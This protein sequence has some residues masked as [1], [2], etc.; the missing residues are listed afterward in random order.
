MAN[1]IERSGSWYVKYRDAAGKW[2]RVVTKARS[3]AEAK[4]MATELEQRS[5]RE[6][7]G[8]EEKPSDCS[9][10]LGQLCEWW[11]A[12]RCPKR[13]LY[14]EQKRLDKHVLKT[15]L[16][17]TPLKV[18]SANHVEDQLRAMEK[19]GLGPASLNGLRGTLFTVLS[20]GRKA[21]KW[22]GANP[23]AD[24]ESRRIPKKVHRTLK[25]EEVPVLLA[26][27][28]DDWLNLFVAALYT[29]MRKGELFGLKKT[30]V[31]LAL[32][33]IV[34]ARS[35][36]NDTTKGGHQDIIPIAAPLAR[37]LR[38]AIKASPSEYVF[39]MPDG[40]MRHKE[41]DPQK[42]LR[43][44]L[45]RAGLVDGY[46]HVCRRC[47]ARGKPSSHLHADAELRTCPTCKMKLWP[48]AL[49]R[50]MH[51]HDLRHTTATLL[52][53]N[54][55][56]LHRVQRILRHKD[57]KLTTDTYGHLEVEDLRTA[58]NTLPT[59]ALPPGEVVDADYEILHGVTPELTP[60]G[61]PVVQD[62]RNPKNETPGAVDFSN[63]SGGF[64]LSGRQD[65][66]LRPLGPEPSALPG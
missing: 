35:Y 13:S 3:K 66:N 6:R 18:L 10:S 37:H 28:P 48:K 55:V 1:V 45:A 8:L 64:L 58:I 7:F 4:R 42:V 40:S 59:N 31:D 49:P 56:D 52:L 57:V 16:G 44:A 61:P 22:T 43:H 19:D 9:L 11:L 15:K 2:T 20:R 27:V 39:P 65:L 24:V 34:V 50:P 63:D 32:G 25:A 60:H 33:V 62:D 38:A 30:D 21:K 36:D 14:I 46:E 41:L 23:V 26:Q 17:S 12:N 51:F 29:G 53:R 54:G 47:K 5:E